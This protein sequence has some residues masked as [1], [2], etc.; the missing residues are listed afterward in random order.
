MIDNSSALGWLYKASFHP[1]EKN[2]HNQVARYFTNFMMKNDHSLY[3]DHIKGSSNNVADSL[4]REFKFSNQ[5]LTDL[6][7]IT[8]T[9]QMPPNFRI[10]KLPDKTISWITLLLE[11]LT[12]KKELKNNSNRKQIRTGKS[13]QTFVE[14]LE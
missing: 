4:S 9:K 5:Q 13:G 7:Y 14:K 11:S 3:A 12:I 10:Q 8:F 6:L 2:K 1:A